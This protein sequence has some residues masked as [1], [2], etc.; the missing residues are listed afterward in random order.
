MK[1]ERGITLM[2]LVLT[3]IVMLILTGVTINIAFMSD[4]GVINEVKTE[5]KMQTEIVE[6]ENKKMNQVLKDLESDW[7]IK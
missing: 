4:N 6:N 3:I 5:T 1:N 7:G 2:V